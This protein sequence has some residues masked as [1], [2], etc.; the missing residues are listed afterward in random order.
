MKAEIRKPPKGSKGAQG[1]KIYIE[2]VYI[3]LVKEISVDDE[4]I[5]WTE[6]E[7]GW[8]FEIKGF[9]MTEEG[10]YYKLKLIP[11]LFE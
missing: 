9:E 3:P 10:N 2:G 7:K 11:K 1:V 6:T 5:K 8:E 4:T